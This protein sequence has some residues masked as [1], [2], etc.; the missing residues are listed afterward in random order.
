MLFAIVLFLFFLK[1]GL[2]PNKNCLIK[3]KELQL[4]KETKDDW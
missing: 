1:S 2:V 3:I 4:R